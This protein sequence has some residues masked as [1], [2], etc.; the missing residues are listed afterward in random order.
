MHQSTILAVDDDPINIE[1]IHKALKDTYR[2]RAATSGAAALKAAFISPYPDIVILD[3]MM[4]DMNGYEVCR[5]LKS[6]PQTK[7]IPV[8]FLTAMS[9][10]EDEAK[11]FAEGAVD[12]IH[13]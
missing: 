11:G 6:D 7:D 9:Q 10:V 2:I 1:L 12:Y 4:P 13:K 5:H 3:I 8:I